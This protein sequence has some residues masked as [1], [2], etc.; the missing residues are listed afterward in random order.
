[1]KNKN[2]FTLTEILLAVMIV[3][4]IGVALASLTTSSTRFSTSG[5]ARVVTRNAMSSFVRQLR[6]DVHEASQVLY[7]RGPF[8]YPP[9]AN[10]GPGIQTLSTTPLLALAKNVDI[11]GG[12]I[13][14]NQEKVYVVY[15]YFGN[16]TLKEEPG[17]TGA[18]GRILYPEGSVLGSIRRRVYKDEEPPFNETG[19]INCGNVVDRK[20]Y[21]VALEFV[22][23]V[24][25]NFGY[26]SPL[27]WVPGYR[28]SAYSV[29][30]E[31]TNRD[32]NLGTQLHVNLIVELPSFPIIHEVL[33]E[34][35]MLPNGY[36]EIRE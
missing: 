36:R 14:D 11:E 27:F 16:P 8:D 15:C 4:L 10:S 30:Q 26:P 7:V 5:R 21:T 20:Y 23:F 29:K 19:E 24:R 31:D 28:N 35:F 25:P 18:S 33:E 2:G 6:Q 32:V 13:D 17:R 3:A 12:A 22:K 1:M 34:S 9:L